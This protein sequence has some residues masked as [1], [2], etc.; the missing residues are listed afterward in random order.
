M[1]A[2]TLKSVVTGGVRVIY[3]STISGKFTTTLKSVT[4]QFSNPKPCRWIS[5]DRL[6]ASVTPGSSYT[7]SPLS[8]VIGAIRYISASLK[9]QLTVRKS[10]NV[11]E[12][13]PKGLQS[14]I[15]HCPSESWAR[16]GISFI[17]AILVTPLHPTSPSEVRLIN[18]ASGDKSEKRFMLLRC[19]GF[20]KTEVWKLPPPSSSAVNAVKPA[21]GERSAIRFFPTSSVVRAVQACNPVKSVMFISCALNSVK[22]GFDNS[23]S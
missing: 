7:A 18:P 10:S 20:Q 1:P 22:R 11:S 17:T 9:P 19:A 13:L 23:V 5:P 14:S 21:R 6:L 3:N 2:R 4:P 15:G 12:Q 16:H 8:C